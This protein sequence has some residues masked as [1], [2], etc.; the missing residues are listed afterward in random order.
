MSIF[1][2]EALSHQKPFFE[3]AFETLAHE[4]IEMVPR[5]ISCGWFDR[6]FAA[7]VLSI[8]FD[9]GDLVAGSVVQASGM[10][11]T[12]QYLLGTMSEAKIMR[13]YVEQGNDP[14]VY[15]TVF[16]ERLRTWSKRVSIQEVCAA[17]H[18]AKL[19]KA[20]ILWAEHPYWPRAMCDLD[21]AAPY[22][23][24]VRGEA[25]TLSELERSISIVGARA[26]SSY[27][28]Y[29]A[30]ELAAG[31]SD[32][33][34]VILSGGAY[35]IDAAVHQTACASEQKT[36]A[37]LAG[38][39][40]QLYPA[41]NSEL[42]HRVMECG[43]LVSESPCGTSPKKWRF[44]MRNRLI[45]AGGLATIVV[46]AG[47]RSGALNTAAHAAELGR[48]L[49]AVPGNVTSVASTGSHRLLREYNATCV[50]SAQ[51]AAELALPVGSQESLAEPIINTHT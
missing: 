23:L 44:L 37:F 7:V 47:M 19:L 1:L 2:S 39:I 33:G 11:E 48:P 49:G 43:A 5:G 35:G 18:R 50:T 8:A 30:G 17:I 22:A 16:Q 26:A 42:F 10:I 34:F 41:G 28:K 32:R 20:K 3:Q 46:E 45:A 6:A 25:S 15:Q 38:G 9:P 4:L 14:N 31:L 12:A 29:V 51:D 21:R 27:G 13:A 24:W 40:D 36:V